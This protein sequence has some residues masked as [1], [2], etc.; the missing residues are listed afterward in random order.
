MKKFLLIFFSLMFF[1]TATVGGGLLLS[2]CNSSYSQEESGEQDSDNENGIDIDEEEN[3]GENGETDE[4]ETGDGQNSEGE[5]SDDDVTAQSTNFNFTIKVVWRNSSSN[6]Y[7][8]NDS[9]YPNSADDDHAGSAGGFDF[10]WYDEKGTYANLTANEHTYS[11]MYGET[12]TQ[13]G[14]D[15]G[16]SR[17]YN[18][19]YMYYKFSAVSTYKRYGVIH[20]SVNTEFFN[21]NNMAFCGVNTNYPNSVCRTETS[22][23]YRIYGSSKITTSSSTAKNNCSGTLTGTY[24]LIFR[25]KD[26]ITYDAN[27]GTGAPASHKVLSGVGYTIP[28]TTPTRTGFRFCGW[29]V[30]NTATAGSVNIKDPGQAIP[31]SSASGGFTWYAVWEPL[32]YINTYYYMDTSSNKTLYNQS[33]TFGKAFTTLSTSSI[34]EYVSNGWSLY[35]WLYNSETGIDRTYA[36]NTSVTSTTYTQSTS[37]LNWYAISSRTITIKYDANGGSGAPSNSTGTQYWNQYG[38]KVSTVSIKLSSTDPTRTGYTFLGWSTSSSATSATYTS[39]AKY[40][41]SNAYNSSASV[42]L[43]AV[44]EVNN[45]TVTYNANGGT[46]RNYN[47][48]TRTSDY[49]ANYGGVQCDLDATTGIVT[50]NGTM[51]ANFEIVRYFTDFSAGNYNIGWKIISGSMTRKAGCFAFEFYTVDNQGLSDRTVTNITSLNTLVSGT[52][53]LSEAMA[54]EAGMLKIWVWYDGNNGGGYT[55][56]NLKIRL[57]TYLDTPA[58]SSQQITYGTQTAL[59][60]ATRTGYTFTGWNTNANGTGTTYGPD[61]IGN[62]TANTTLYAQWK[63]NSYTVTWNGNATAGSLLASGLWNYAGS[64]GYTSSSTGSNSSYTT[65]TTGV[66]ATSSV[67]YN[68]TISY[69]TPIPIRSGY[70]F[71]GWYTATSGGTRI[72]DSSGNLVASVSGYT[73]SSRQ[74]IRAGNTTLYAQWSVKTYSITYNLGGGSLSS[75]P[76][77]YSVTTNRTISTPTRTGYTFTGWSVT[78]NLDKMY[79]G[80]IDQYTGVQSYNSAYPNAVYYEM[81]YMVNGIRYTGALSNGVIRFRAYYSDGTYSG[82]S[83]SATNTG[84]GKYAMLW[85]HLGNTNSQTQVTFN[86]GNT[87]FTTSGYS[88]VGDLEITANWTPNIYTITLNKQSGSGGANTIYLKYNTGWYSN[89]SATTSISTITP[90][91]RTGFTFQGYYTGTNGTGTQ[92][93]NSNGEINSGRTT[94]TTSN[95][96]LHAN[97][98]AKNPAR[99]DSEKGYWY[100]EMGMYP[101]T[102]ATQTEIN[103]I[104]NTNG[105]VYTIKGKNVT[106]KVGANSI[107]YCQY[108]GVWYKVEPVRYILNTS[109]INET[110]FDGNDFINLGREYMYTDAI[111]VSLWAYMDNWADYGTS[112]GNGNM[113]LI[114]CTEGGGWNIESSDDNN[115]HIVAYD[116]GVGYKGVILG[117]WTTLS[118]GWHHFAFTFDGEYL[119]GYLDGELKG[120]S[121]KF[122]SGEIAYNSTNSIFIGAEP[123]NSPTTPYGQYFKGKIRNVFIF[124]NSFNKDEILDLKSK[125]FYTGYGTESGNY[126]AVTEKAVFVSAWS[127][128]KLSLG[129]GYTSSTLRTN[130]SDFVSDSKMNTDYTGARS[131][132]I[133]N[134][135]NVNGASADTT[136]SVDIVVSNDSEIESIFGDL[137]AEFSD[138]VSDIL[139]NNLMYWTRDVG[140]NLNTAE[141]ISSLGASTQTIMQKTLGVRLTANVSIF[142]CL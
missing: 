130:I 117:K 33:R 125:D 6:A 56:N 123:N 91:T 7:V 106:S 108:N 77:T 116:R 112:S 76:T 22:S 115:I 54:Q 70:T 94:I 18:L 139:G 63:A 93:I 88:L 81:F 53:S 39:G 95:I 34:S 71:N 137:R 29:S 23:T 99:Y 134:F 26:T 30:S 50:L 47:Y 4:G 64:S 8:S 61:N 41:F 129:G 126:L 110:Y 124:N 135:R 58:I 60:Y 128:T 98:S 78:M 140:S 136:L 24:Y 101:Q 69:K 20:P 43:Y 132:T 62:I 138:L 66:T 5:E 68:S 67:T 46:M 92:I 82:S 79:S 38:N 118:S 104:T 45:Y 37:T 21:S 141:C 44:W 73:S 75:Q 32:K 121:S 51:T 10:Y 42:T 27:G 11:A 57:Y 96:S 85:Y 133:R 83:G 131:Y 90:P 9:N 25:T 89:S 12:V 1:T 13:D 72:A 114:S 15:K 120:T 17:T 111:T 2:G 36:P 28:S 19:K 109:L 59:A 113:R 107:E 31:D 3:K 103:G 48:A 65:S 52:L 119:K 100:V 127:N 86:L 105:A 35:G 16:T 80:Q 87:S 49:S 97:W 142:G 74:W 102:R 40:S 55:F 14:G 122:A 84:L